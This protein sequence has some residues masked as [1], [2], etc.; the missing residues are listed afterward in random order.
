VRA[1]APKEEKKPWGMIRSR[2]QEE[3]KE[4]FMIEWLQT[5]NII[6]HL[7]KVV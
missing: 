6:E 3:K 1:A 7:F 2:D 5:N 4:K